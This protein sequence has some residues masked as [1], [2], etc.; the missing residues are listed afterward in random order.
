MVSSNVAYLP[1][2]LSRSIG[3]GL[4]A[5]GEADTLSAWIGVSV[6]IRHMPKLGELRR[7]RMPRVEEGRGPRVGRVA[8]RTR[9]I[10]RVTEAGMDRPYGLAARS[11][12]DAYG[13]C[14]NHE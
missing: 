2:I 13:W 10:R 9:R 11:G 5:I 4:S 14:G 1:H 7:G 12:T 3:Y 6:E 8:S